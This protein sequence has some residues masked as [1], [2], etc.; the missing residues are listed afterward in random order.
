[1]MSE[2]TAIAGKAG[3]ELQIHYVLLSSL[4]DKFLDRNSKKHDLDTLAESV[5]RYSFRDPIAFDSALNGGTGGIVEGNGRLS[6][7][8]QIKEQGQPAPRGIKAKGDDWFVPVVFGVDAE[9]END[10][11]AY[12][13]SHNLSALWGSDLIFLDQSRLFDKELLKTQLTGL[14][15]IDIELLPVGLDVDDLDIFL[16]PPSVDSDSQIE[17]GDGDVDDIPSQFGVIIFCQDEAEQF[18]LLDKALREGKKCKA[19]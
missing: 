17:E 2:L 19:L 16:N 7:L 8:L 10:A 11:I 5:N 12:S 18:E 14:A 3:D 6:Y 13:I 4:A 1:M 15:D 9:D